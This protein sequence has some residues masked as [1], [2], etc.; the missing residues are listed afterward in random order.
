MDV[1]AI[2]AKKT[3][4]IM[5]KLKIKNYNVFIIKFGHIVKFYQLKAEY[6]KFTEEKKK[7]DETENL[8]LVLCY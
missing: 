4:E 5:V 6:T 1:V 8:F 3:L 2:I 7:E